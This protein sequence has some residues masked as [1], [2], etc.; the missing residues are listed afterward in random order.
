[1]RFN[2]Y[3]NKATRLESFATLSCAYDEVAR[4]GETN[5]SALECIIM[6]KDFFHKKQYGFA[7][8]WSTESLAHSVGCF[9][10]KHKA[11]MAMRASWGQPK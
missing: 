2:A 10:W 8:E 3:D 9:S 6:A 1:M 4:A 11:A 7:H 5:S